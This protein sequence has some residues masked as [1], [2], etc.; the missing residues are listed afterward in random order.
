MPEFIM[1]YHDDSSRMPSNPEDGA[2]QQAKFM[3]W[4]QGLG[5]TVVNPGTPFGQAKMVSSSGV[6]EIDGSNRLSGFSTIKADSLDAAVEIVKS[7]PYLV[8][9]D[10]R[11][12]EVMQMG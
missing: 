7:C 1:A 3:E 11:V 9:G 5:D 8:Y 2:A 10:I 4:M 6:S 12:A